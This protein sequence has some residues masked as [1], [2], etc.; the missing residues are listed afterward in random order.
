VSFAGTLTGDGGG[1]GDPPPPPPPPPV[2]EHGNVIARIGQ[3]EATLSGQ[4]SSDGSTTRTALQSVRDALGIV[5]NNIEAS[6]AGAVLRVNSETS[7]GISNLAAQLGVQS[8]DLAFAIKGNGIAIEK[9]Q[10]SIEAKLLPEILKGQDLTQITQA[11]VDEVGNNFLGQVLSAGTGVLGF[12]SGGALLPVAGFVQN[13]IMEVVN[14][15]LRPDRIVKKAMAEFNRGLKRVKKLFSMSG[16]AFSLP[17]ERHAV[18]AITLGFAADTVD[19]PE[20]PAD[21]AM[22]KL[23]GPD[24]EED[25]AYGAYLWFQ[26]AYQTLVRPEDKHPQHDG[27]CHDPKHNHY[28][29]DRDDWD[30]E[31]KE[32]EKKKQDW[33]RDRNNWERDKDNWERE[34]KD[35]E[36]KAKGR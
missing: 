28:D 34:K 19:I 22:E 17:W 9:V 6:I 23:L 12:F 36:K 16:P 7:L 30:R 8:Q 26:R 11:K 35:L 24:R 25:T 4:I 1:D 18:E 21:P 10:Q 29:R 2:D 15:K 33:D 5:E 32:W 20:F 14:G 13:A 31:R 27:D 3:A